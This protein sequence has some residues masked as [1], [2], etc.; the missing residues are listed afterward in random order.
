VLVSGGAPGSIIV[1]GNSVNGAA[2]S[3][4]GVQAGPGSFGAFT[5]VTG[6]DSL[7]AAG[8]L[9]VT[10]SVSPAAAPINYNPFGY[11]TI[12]LP[13]SALRI[14]NGGNVR[15]ALPLVSRSDINVRSVI[16][17]HN[18]T[19]DAINLVSVG[20]LSVTQTVNTQGNTFGG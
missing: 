12:N 10:V 8:N 15:M 16:A 4:S 2:L 9:P 19:P 5:G 6:P 18:V 17:D 14:N 13:G 7:E 11:S 1:A 3:A 20:N